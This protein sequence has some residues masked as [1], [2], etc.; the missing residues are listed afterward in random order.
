MAASDNPEIDDPTPKP[1]TDAEELAD[2]GQ[3]DGDQGDEVQA[4]G[5]PDPA[6]E[7]VETPATSYLYEDPYG[8]D[9]T[10]QPEYYDLSLDF[11]SYAEDLDPETIWLSYAGLDYWE[12]DTNQYNRENTAAY[13]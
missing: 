10:Y 12:T 5:E 3:V 13:R 2:E 4:D 6:E 11:V 8:S 7:H 1:L 9:Y